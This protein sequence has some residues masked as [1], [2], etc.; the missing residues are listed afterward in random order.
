MKNSNSISESIKNNPQWILGLTGGI[1]SGKSTASAI[2]AALGCSVVDADISARTVVA[3]NSYGLNMVV[4]KF[5][6]EIL[7]K[8]GTLNRHKL[9]DIVFNNQQH[10]QTLN[11]ILHPLIKE[12]ILQKLREASGCYT[13]LAAPLLFENHLEHIPDFILCMDIDEETQ[14]KRI[15]SRDGSSIEIAKAIINA[16]LPRSYKI[17][18][19]DQVIKSDFPKPEDMTNTIVTLHQKFLKLAQAKE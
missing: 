12:D 18:H 15:C 3:P 11:K 10:M 14:I 8:D 17:A 6:L 9:R 16:Q 5:G 4:S 13:V 1:C 7:N 19:S 2:F